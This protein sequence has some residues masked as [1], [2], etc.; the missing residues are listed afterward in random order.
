MWADSHATALKSAEKM[1]LL[2]IPLGMWQMDN[3]VSLKKYSISNRGK[4]M[5]I[6]D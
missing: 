3:L 5:G 4:Y 2:Y 6:E 1:G